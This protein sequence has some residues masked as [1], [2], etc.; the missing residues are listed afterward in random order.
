MTPEEI[1][2]PE[3]FEKETSRFQ[4]VAKGSG[5]STSDIRMLIK[6]YKMLRDLA[7]SQEAMSG[8]MLDQ[9]TL[10]KMARKLGKK[11]MFRM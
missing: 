7:K 11:K 3:I 9:K 5:T 8:G 2:N 6:Q 10:M 1:E 4:R